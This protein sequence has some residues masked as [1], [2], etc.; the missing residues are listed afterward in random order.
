M[1][2]APLIAPA[3]GPMVIG[4]EEYDRQQ[5]E[6][7][8]KGNYGELVTGIPATHVNGPMVGDGTPDP[9]TKT[10]KPL[11]KAQQKAKD[12]ADAL[13]AEAEA[14]AKAEADELARVAGTLSVL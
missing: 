6:L 3:Y 12:E 8:A 11:T 2:P 1:S 10:E 9:E 13:A 5:A 7:E 14:K 4:Q